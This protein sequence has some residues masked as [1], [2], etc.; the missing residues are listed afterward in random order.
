MWSPFP[1][2]GGKAGMTGEGEGE[3]RTLYS[4]MDYA[5]MI[6]ESGQPLAHDYNEELTNEDPRMIAFF[7]SLV[8]KDHESSTDSELSSTD[9]DYDGDDEEK[10]SRDVDILRRIR[11]VVF[12]QIRNLRENLSEESD[13]SSTTESRTTDNVESQ[14]SDVM[15]ES[16]ERITNNIETSDV[17]NSSEP[18]ASYGEE[19]VGIMRLREII[20]SQQGSTNIRKR[21]ANLRRDCLKNDDTAATSKGFSKN[22]NEEN[23]SKESENVLSKYSISSKFPLRGKLISQ[24]HLNEFSECST[25]SNPWREKCSSQEHRNEFPECST[26]SSPLREKCSSQKHRNE[27]PECSTSSNSWRKR[28][29]S[30]KNVPDSSSSSENEDKTEKFKDLTKRN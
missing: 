28:L 17:K 12:E 4:P 11:A 8:Q 16:V 13:N 30:R 7:D 27:F 1:M 19:G 21:I 6:L 10:S 3:Q 15:E 5:R 14:S 9:D 2:S 23:G 24:K 29:S 22:E 18:S 25:S 26:S 20:T